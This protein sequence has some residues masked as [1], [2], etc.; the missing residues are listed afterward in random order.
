MHE[1]NCLLEMENICKSYDG[2]Q[3]L[4][5][6]ELSIFSNEIVGLV[7]ENG[8]GKSTL[9]K[10][11]SG[12]CKRDN[13]KIRIK[14]QPAKIN[15]PHDGLSLGISMIYQ[16]P[17]L[18]MD[19]T[20][21]ENIFLGQEPS[22]YGK[23]IWRK[24]YYESQKILDK[25]KSSINY[26]LI[27]RYLS[28]AEMQIVEIARALTR[29]SLII[30]MDEVT[31]SLNFQEVDSL[32]SLIKQ[33]K[34]Q[35]KNIS[36]IFISHR[37]NEI[38]SIT[39]R[40]VVLRDGKTVTS[41]ITNNTCESEVIK[42]MIGGGSLNN[43][44]ANP[45][46]LRR[47][48]KPVLLELKEVCLKDKLD[49]INLAVHEGEIV[50]LTGLKGSGLQ[51]L[52]Q[53][54]IGQLPTSEGSIKYSGEIIHKLSPKKLNKLGVSLIPEDRKKQGLILRSSVAN[55]IV[56][57]ALKKISIFGFIH[58]KKQN[59]IV[60]YF[61]RKFG[62]IAKGRNSEVCNLSGGNQ[63]KV[64]MAKCLANS[65][66][67]LIC[68]EPTRG[69]DVSAKVQVR[70]FLLELASK[71]MGILYVSSEVNEI[72]KICNTIIVLYEGNIACS[73]LNHNLNEERIMLY[74]TSGIKNKQI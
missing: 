3:A 14:G 16:E 65:P 47:T 39:D 2:I 71:G 40:I 67:L 70:S 72:L 21:A 11:L 50:G 34:S 58:L 17:E 53:V 4:K 19:L 7:G 42:S 56:L 15:N 25:L 18:V 5:G 13:G 61:I 26:K 31:S 59:D 24:M 44:I 10:I 55:N 68:C 51:E 9:L 23:I 57:S 37:L 49:K 69:I 12:Y 38:F 20:V 74:A 28:I 32:F 54:L 29:S 62:I 63:Q 33:L 41:F 46:Q 8:A 43:K 36:V 66:F 27:V 45:I 64:V 35:N 52:V 60:D 1:K 30:I 73:L 22:K 6:A 48:L